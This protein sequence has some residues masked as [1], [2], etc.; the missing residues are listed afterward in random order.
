VKS[1]LKEGDGSFLFPLSAGGAQRLGDNI[2]EVSQ[3]G[4]CH[5]FHHQATTPS[6]AFFGLTCDYLAFQNPP[7]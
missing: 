6:A 7:C 3:L 5:V 2:Y 1:G 4:T